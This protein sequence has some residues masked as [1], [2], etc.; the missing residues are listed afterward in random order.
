MHTLDLM[1]IAAEAGIVCNLGKAR[2]FYHADHEQYVVE[3]N[4]EE[5][6]LEREH[7]NPV[8]AVFFAFEADRTLSLISPEFVEA[9]VS[10]LTSEGV[11]Q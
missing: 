2:A 7:D 5:Q 4:G 10:S 8:D 1:A 6:L 11:F 3:V 9:Y